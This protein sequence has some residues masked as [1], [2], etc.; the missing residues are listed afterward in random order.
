MRAV[1]ASVLWLLVVG[2]WSADA[3]ERSVVLGVVQWVAGTRMVM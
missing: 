2:L 1:A 3:W